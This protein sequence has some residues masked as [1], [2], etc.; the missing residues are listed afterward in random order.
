MAKDKKD[1]KDK[2]KKDKKDKGERMAGERMKP[3][4]M[5]DLRGLGGKYFYDDKGELRRRT[6]ERNPYDVEL[7]DYDLSSTGRRSAAGEEYLGSGELRALRR[8]GPDGEKRSREEM[9]EYA[10]TLDQDA[11]SGKA[12]SVLERWKNKIANANDPITEEPEPEPINDQPLP[13]EEVNEVEI[14]GK[15]GAG[16][17]GSG[18]AIGGNNDIDITGQGDKTWSGNVK[19]GG[20]NYGNIN[21]DSSVNTNTNQFLN[22]NYGDSRFAKGQGDNNYMAPALAV[23]AAA[24]NQATAGNAGAGLSTVVGDYSFDK[25]PNLRARNQKRIDDVGATTQELYDRGELLAVKLYGPEFGLN[26]W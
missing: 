6:E 15:G 17:I 21:S 3:E 20:D 19:V 24:Q 1:K 2:D 5:S 4:E 13:V 16:V 23:M 9:L 25:I 11:I 7:E 18:T 10:A 22:A 14:G 8:N 26:P 12:Q